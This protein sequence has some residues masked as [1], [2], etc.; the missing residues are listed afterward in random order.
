M[1]SQASYKAHLRL[2]KLQTHYLYQLEVV[3]LAEN[4]EKTEALP[5]PMAPIVRIMK[6]NL[7][8]DKLIKK[9]VKQGMNKWMAEMCEKVAKKMNTKPYASVD[10]SA[11]KE[12]IDIYNS[13]EELEKEKQRILA[14]LEKIKQDCDS[15]MRDL[16]R[17][18][19][20]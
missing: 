3:D 1:W 7:D 2:Y 5:L 4:T 8:K 6:K 9:E 16:D 20:V 19:K 11:F 12:A 15:L 18:F 13:I 14:N 10:L 17:K